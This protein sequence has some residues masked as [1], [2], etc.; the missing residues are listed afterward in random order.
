MTVGIL[1]AGLAG[2]SAAR[3]LDLDSELLE[4]EARP[5][6]LCRSAEKDGFVYD[7]GGHILFS[8]DDVL[9]QSLLELVGEQAIRRR[10]NNKILLKDRFIKYPFE[11]ELSALD[12]EDIFD[13]LYHYIV[14]DHPTPTNFSQWMYATFGKGI[15]ELYLLPYNRKIWKTD[16]AE[17]SMVW[18]ERVPS[19]PVADII[20]SAIG[21]PTE[22]Y[23]HQLHFY[24]PQAG[25]IEALIHGAAAATLGMSSSSSRTRDTTNKI[26][27]DF[28]IARIEA[29]GD[30]WLVVSE[31]GQERHFE[32]LISTI[33]IQEL[34]GALVDCPQEIRETV[35]RLRYN[36]VIVVLAGVSHAKL[37]DFTAIYVPD[38]DVICHRVCF[39][40]NFSEA[41]SP[42]GCSSLMA[43][44]TAPPGSELAGQPDAY[45]IDQ[46]TDWMVQRG[47][48]EG[49]EI[50]AT[51]VTRA[52]YAYVVSDLEYEKNLAVVTEYFEGRGIALCGRFGTFNYWNMDQVLGNAMEVAAGINAT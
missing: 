25:G 51:D 44:I 36:S 35:G 30:G 14:N 31:A 13:C 29:E 37:P 47:W 42:E 48:C 24:Y 28:R 12:K 38:P 17:M 33:P 39:N 10:R 16:P 49:K 9:L 50:V 11:N 6:G 15:A 5:G 40:N 4:A 34:A 3:F 1:G 20:K 43:E 7:L 8:R 2:L 52:Q 32:K 46:V 23:L 18:V 21:I 22:G 27:V 45:F 26:T 19:P 41:N